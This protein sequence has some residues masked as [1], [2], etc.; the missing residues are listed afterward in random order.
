MFESRV[1]G[2]VHVLTPR[3]NLVGGEETKALAGAIASLPNPKVILDLQRINWVS[4]LGVEGLR[5]MHQSCS[6]RDGWLRLI[7]VGT[8]IK[9]VL[10]TMRLH[11]VFPTFDAPEEAIAAPHHNENPRRRAAPTPGI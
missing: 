1:V 4:S 9:D 8:R 7:Y 10:L 5:R 2:D 6:D 11:W 3:K